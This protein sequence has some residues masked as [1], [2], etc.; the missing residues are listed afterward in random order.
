MQQEITSHQ[1]LVEAVC[2]KAMQLLEQTRD[3]SLSEYLTT[4]KSLFADVVTKSQ[5]LLDQLEESVRRHAQL[6][7]MSDEFR[8]W[9]AKQRNELA[10]LD[11]VSGEKADLTRRLADLKALQVRLSTGKRRFNFLSKGIN[12]PDFMGESK[13]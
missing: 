4:I 11:D 5:R 2:E 8:D 7:A 10:A 1:Q 6:A 9:L 3:Q 12:S 13:R